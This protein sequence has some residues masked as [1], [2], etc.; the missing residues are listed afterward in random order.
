M[1]RICAIA[2]GG[3]AAVWAPPL[4]AAN[5]YVDGDCAIEGNG[6]GDG[7]ATSAGGVGAHRD[8]QACLTSAVAGDVC[9]VKNGTYTTTNNGGDPSENG[10][11]HFD[12]SGTVDAP[13]TLR[14]YPGHAPLLQNCPSEQTSYCVRPTLTAFNR[15]YVVIEGLRI[16]GGIWINGASSAVGAGSR[17]IVLR[18]L[19]MTQGWGEIDDGNWA[20]IFLH[21][22]AGARVDHNDIHDI[23]VSSG[24]GQQSSG[25][26]IKL[27]Q[28]TDSVIESNTCRSVNIP[29]SQAGGI[30]DKAQATRNILRYNW[31]ENV[32]ICV[33]INNQL[34]STQDQVYGNVCIGRGDAGRAAVRLITNVDRIDVFNNTFYGFAEAL[35]IMSEGGPITDVRYYGNISAAN[36]EKNLE[37]YQPGLSLSNYNAWQ[38]G[39]SFLYGGATRTS[40]AAFRTAT[41][42]DAQSIEGDCRFVAPGSDFHLKPESPC[43]GASR[44]GGTAAG[45][46]VDIGA[47]GVTSCVGHAC[48][49][50]NGAPP[51]G[52]GEADAGT[53]TADAGDAGAA[54]QDRT[55]D[56][57]VPDI[58]VGCSATRGARPD[59]SA[60]IALPALALLRLAR[61]RAKHP[62]R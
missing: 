24:G 2:I 15:E 5:R 14:N 51:S 55:L 36:T 59:A 54:A 27:Y 25:T 28:N 38:S 32:N 21:N 20:P 62:S 58:H 17:G 18:R 52:G 60:L 8:P 37:G 34:Q 4:F 29:E 45:T 47:Y 12:H 53:P 3:L 43:I 31:I 33:R 35:Q 30:D 11:Y 19:E 7:C 49:G 42:L 23:S 41:S 22:V 50:P 13:I 16:R 61:R 44:T 57:N 48:A 40:L 9:L 26:C 39:R 10:G 6:L 1:R 56:I 46:S